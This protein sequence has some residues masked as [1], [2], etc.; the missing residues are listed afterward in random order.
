MTR[1]LVLLA[2]VAAALL[3]PTASA[4]PA[5]PADSRDP[6]GVWPLR[7]QPTVV[8]P[9][10]PPSVVWGAGHRGVDLGGRVGQPVRAALAGRVGFVGRIAGVGVVV[11]DHGATRTTYQPV[12]AG[13]SRGEEVEAGAVLGRLQWYGTHCLPRTCLHWGWLRG[14]QYL[15]PLRLVGGGPRPVRLLPLGG[16]L[17]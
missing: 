5:A 9:F 2:L 3:A 14:D 12:A 11:V 17:G 13:V 10:D 1:A 6:V 7:P 16:L 8:E 15:D 4:A